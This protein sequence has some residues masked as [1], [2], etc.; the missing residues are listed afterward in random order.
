M[1]DS[2]FIVSDFGVL[3]N[4]IKHINEVRANGDNPIVS[5]KIG[6]L[7]RSIQQNKLMHLW[8]R[9][10]AKS[11][12]GSIKMESGRCKYQYFL[13]ILENSRREGARASAFIIKDMEQRYGR[14]RIYKLLGGIGSSKSIIATTSLLSTKEFNKALTMMQ[15]GEKEHN[16]TDPSTLGYNM[17]Y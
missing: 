16:L 11:K 2:V 14:E 5:V 17:F 10:I 6:D 1:S 9:D 13:P 15:R 7:D 4:L 8:F 3:G 12:K